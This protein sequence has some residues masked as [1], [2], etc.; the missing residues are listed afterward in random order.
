MMPTSAEEPTALA[1]GR[2]P[3]VQ[4]RCN[5]ICAAAWVQ[6]VLSSD[7]LKLLKEPTKFEAEQPTKLTDCP[8]IFEPWQQTFPP[9]TIQGLLVIQKLTTAASIRVAA[10]CAISPRTSLMSSEEE[11]NCV[12]RINVRRRAN[13]T[14]R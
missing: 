13:R 14:S 4:R 11:M 6:D 1:Y 3:T 12:R 8:V 2:L 9:Q 7:C 10:A 5:P